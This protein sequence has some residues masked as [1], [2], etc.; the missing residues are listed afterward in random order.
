MAKGDSF[1][2]TMT[3]C[4]VTTF[5]PVPLPTLPAAGCA[6]RLVCTNGTLWLLVQV[7]LVFFLFLTHIG[8]SEPTIRS[9]DRKLKS[10]RRTL[11]QFPEDIV[12]NVPAMRSL[13]HD[14]AKS[15]HK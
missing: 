10:A 8:L 9:L 11:L 4:Q 15:N 1:M 2:V 6:C 5:C 7:M 14:F 13:I 3:L 12:N